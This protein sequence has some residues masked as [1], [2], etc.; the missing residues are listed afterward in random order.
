M[1]T[2]SP[3]FLLLGSCEYATALMEQEG[4]VRL[5]RTIDLINDTIPRIEGLGGYKVSTAEVPYGTGAYD[6]DILRMVI[7]CSDRGLSG[8]ATQRE[9]LKRGI[10]VEGAD[11]SNLILICT[12]ADTPEDYDLLV[13]GLASV[14]G[15]MYSLEH[16]VTNAD[17]QAAFTSEMA[18]PMRKAAMAK[19]SVVRLG[20]SVGRIAAV[21][22]GAFPPGVPIVLPG[23][24]ISKEAAH[25][26]EYLMRRG[27]G[28][29]GCGETIRVVEE[30]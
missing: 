12:I 3:S 21:S 11:L 29:F 15:G 19:S 20:E 13:R 18:M 23:Q 14:N 5:A 28:V 30:A 16:R 6:R 4:A 17:V 9:L 10:A 2:T 7:D 8:V 27:L 1:Q 24:R 22:A 26:L 25:V